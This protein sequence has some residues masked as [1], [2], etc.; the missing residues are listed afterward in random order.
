[1]PSGGVL[2]GGRDA[3]W[4]VYCPC[5]RAH[6]RAQRRLRSHGA[7]RELET[8]LRAD[9]RAAGSRRDVIAIGDH[10]TPRDT[11]IRDT[12]EGLYA[13]VARVSRLAMRRGPATGEPADR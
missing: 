1:M 13:H 12:L 4:R 6:A 11:V 9:R 2:L 10:F 8:V 3:S 7:S 5:A